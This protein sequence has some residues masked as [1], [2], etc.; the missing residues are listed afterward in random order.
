[1]RWINEEYCQLDRSPAALRRFG[2]TVGGAFLLLGAGLVWRQ[3]SAGWLLL[4]FCALL[5]LAAL[6]APAVLKSFHRL[7]MTL[8][9]AL[10]WVM[11][12]VIL[13]VVFYFVVTPIGLLQ[14]LFAKPA[15]DLSF[16]S[17][18][19]SYWETRP[20]TQ[21]TRDEYEKQF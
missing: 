10:G 17:G 3:H 19:Q 4:V 14:R 16:R 11:T 8:A 1:M 7:W 9:L 2:V 15:M 18:A 6:G 20:T 13:T 21:P 5:L 12:S